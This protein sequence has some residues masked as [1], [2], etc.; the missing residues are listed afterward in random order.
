MNRFISF[1]I[2]LCFFLS[3]NAEK[4]IG[5]YRNL[6][7]GKDLSVQIATRDGALTH[8]YIEIPAKDKETCMIDL[9]SSK[10]DKFRNSLQILREKFFQIGADDMLSKKESNEIVFSD[11]KFP[12]VTFVWKVGNKFYSSHNNK[13]LPTYTKK[14]SSIFVHAHNTVVS[15]TNQFIELTY[16]FVF[17]NPLEIDELLK[18]ISKEHVENNLTN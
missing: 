8:L 10:V 12:L 13:I 9:T 18:I 1:F 15:N 3:V 11:I 4:A 17:M 7:L 14:E 16:Y 6:F 5:S 2:F